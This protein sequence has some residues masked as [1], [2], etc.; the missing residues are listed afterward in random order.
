MLYRL[1]VLPDLVT[2]GAWKLEM[3]LGHTYAGSPGVLCCGGGL[4]LTVYDDAL[5]LKTL[6]SASKD[7]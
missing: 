1:I 4:P 2:V 6:P 5:G 3:S 7:D